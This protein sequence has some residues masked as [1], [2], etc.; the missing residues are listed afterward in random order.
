[1][2]SS[3]MKPKISF[4]LAAFNEEDNILECIESCL[5]QTYE[6]IE[7]CVTDDG[8]SDST[9]SILE[10]LQSDRVH[11]NRFEKNKGKVAAFNASYELA[12]GDFIAIIGADDVNLPKR[13]EKQYDFLIQQDLDLTWG[14]FIHIDAKGEYLPNYKTPLN[15]EPSRIDILQDNF[16]P[17]NT[18]FFK[19]VLAQDI[20]PIPETL[21]FEDWW[22]SYNT[23]FNYKYKILNEPV[24]NYRIHENNT[25]GNQQG[26]YVDNRRKNIQRHFAYH[27]L[28]EERLG[29]NEEYRK[30]NKL[31]RLYKQACMEDEFLI[32]V[33]HFLKSFKFFSV[34]SIKI[35]IKFLFITLLGLRGIGFILRK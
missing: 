30:I 33:Q 16:I 29:T 17:G 1:M 27:D 20:F 10:S 26:Q 24:I 34:R 32:R 12:T 13:I 3:T 2:I 5:N 9:W 8:S 31:V 7:I 18:I 35:S 4:V 19:R 21:K 14:G 15:K 25:V 11:I 22:I 6:N 23:I 28:F